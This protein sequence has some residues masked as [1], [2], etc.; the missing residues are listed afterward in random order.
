MTL[1]SHV[2]HGVSN[3]RKRDNLF[4]GLFRPTTKRTSRLTLTGLLWGKS[5]ADRRISL[6]HKGSVMWK[7]FSCDYVISYQMRRTRDHFGYMLRNERLP[8]YL[9][10][11]L[12][13]CWGNNPI[14]KGAQKMEP[15]TIFIELLEW[16]SFRI[17]MGVHILTK[18]GWWFGTTKRSTTDVHIVA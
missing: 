8:Q 16:S 2:C 18:D 1:A 17:E 5:A 9:E 11:P 14:P 13:L 7:L 4:S 6:I 3:H 10:W 12:Y 15:Y